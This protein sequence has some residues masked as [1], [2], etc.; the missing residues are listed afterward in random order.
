M[1]MAL[2]TIGDTKKDELKPALL[3]NHRMAIYLI[4]YNLKDCVVTPR[5]IE[6]SK[7]LA[8]AVT[9]SAMDSIVVYKDRKD[10]SIVGQ[11][12]LSLDQMRMH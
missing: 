3:G 1:V 9:C 7:L 6:S 2:H 5:K 4:S 12:Q 11:R 8:P 10:Y